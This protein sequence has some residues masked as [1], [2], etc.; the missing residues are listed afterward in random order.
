MTA[1]ST[2]NRESYLMMVQGLELMADHYKHAWKETGWVRFNRLYADYGL[3]L[4]FVWFHEQLVKFSNGI[5]KE[6]AFYRKLPKIDCRSLKTIR[7]LLK[8]RREEKRIKSRGVYQPRVRL[9]YEPERYFR[10]GKIAVYIAMFGGYDQIMEPIIHPDNVD[11]FILSDK[12]VSSSSKWKTIDYRRYIPSAYT[13]DPILCNRWCKMHPH[14]LFPDYDTSIYLDSNIMV[15]SDL[16]PLVT[17]MDNFPVSMF[18]HRGRSCVYQE[19]QT[20]IER[21]LDTKENLQQH[22]KRIR[23]QGIPENWGLLEA[24]V[25]ARCHHDERC[26]MLM[27][28]WWDNFLSGSRRDQISLIETLWQHG[29]QPQQLATLGPNVY[30]CN[31]FVKIGHRRIVRKR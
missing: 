24:P 25:I 2:F 12:P 30:L 28:T 5:G 11:Y 21:G 14:I 23:D 29:I 9:S 3:R 26:K 19:L 4:G 7:S 17:F 27:N 15:V 20:C 31:L 10:N 18:R 1:N 22:E 6:L 13:E 16:T 8:K